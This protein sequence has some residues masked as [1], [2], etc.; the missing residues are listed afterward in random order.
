MKHNALA[1][2]AKMW[3]CIFNSRVAKKAESETSWLKL[4]FLVSRKKAWA[5]FCEV[6]QFSLGETSPFSFLVPRRHFLWFLSTLTSSNRK[7]NRSADK[8]V[9]LTCVTKGNLEGNSPSPFPYSNSSITQI[10]NS[11]GDFLHTTCRQK[12]FLTELLISLTEIKLSERNL[13][14][15]TSL[16][17]WD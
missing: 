16:T 10:M 5:D 1:T 12:E 4:L 3:V 8:V 17:C 11:H 6:R 2:S 7:A 13:H 9:K 14:E 15:E